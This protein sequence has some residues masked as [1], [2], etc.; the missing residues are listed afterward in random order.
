MRLRCGG[1]ERGVKKE[2]T[3]A[4]TWRKEGRQKHE[5]EV[6]EKKGKEE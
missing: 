6:E 1:E 2:E 5:G 4:G 3:G